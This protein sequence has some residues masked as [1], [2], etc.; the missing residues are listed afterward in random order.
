M[1]QQNLTEDLAFVR[2]M[3][4]EGASAPCLSGRFSVWWGSLVTLALLTHWATL[5]GLVPIEPQ[6]IGA[7]WVVMAVVGLIGSSLL[8]RSLRHKPGGSAPGNRASASV[9]PVSTAAI[10]LYATAIGFAVAFR[11]APS[12]LFDTII[13]LTFAIYAVMRATGAVLFRNRASW[14][15]V[16]VALAIVAVSMYLV[17]RP[18]VYLIAALGVVMTQILPGIM[19]L[20]AEPNSIV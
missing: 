19:G 6:W 3:A 13:P 20:R 9:W 17:G 18:E 2:Q 11:D 8:G 15:L 5:R 16:L 7:I 12:I 4:E 1:N 14:T 10:F